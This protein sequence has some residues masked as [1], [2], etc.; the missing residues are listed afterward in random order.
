MSDEVISA[1]YVRECLSSN[2]WNEIK[3]LVPQTTIDILELTCD[4]N[5]YN[6]KL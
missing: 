4:L 5:Q 2:N 1:T 3:K 6:E